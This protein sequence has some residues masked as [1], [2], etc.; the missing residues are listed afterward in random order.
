M[1]VRSLPIRTWKA[2]L[3]FNAGQAATLIDPHDVDQIAAGLKQL[4]TQPDLRQ[5]CIEQGYQQI[6]NFSW[7]QAAAQLLEILENVTLDR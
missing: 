1:V 4:I 3:P 2:R 5:R 6:K 7:S